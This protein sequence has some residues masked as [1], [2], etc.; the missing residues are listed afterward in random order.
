MDFKEA[1]SKYF[2][3]KGRLEA[4]ALT[5]EQFQSQVGQLRVQ[6]AQGRYWAIDARS[7]GWLHY[8]GASWVPSQPPEGVSP[9]VPPAPVPVPRRGG[10]PV[11]LIGGLAIAV[12]LCLVALGGAGLIF[13][14]PGGGPEGGEEAAAISEEEAERLADDIISEQFPDLKDAE[15]TIGSYENPA[16]TEFWTVTYSR[17]VEKESGGQTYT[18]PQIV[19]ISV[20]KDTGET[21]AAVSS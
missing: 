7:G 3:L 15:K 5:L 11:L 21:T 12:I 2:E 14:R 20:D 1:E 18:I 13:T 16:G 9:L 10:P 17:E 8:D 19:I 4:G 6:D